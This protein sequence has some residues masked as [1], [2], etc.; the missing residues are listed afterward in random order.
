MPWGHIETLLDKLD[1]PAER[2]W[3]AAQAV[4]HG[5]TRNLLLNQIKGQL[6]LRV[7]AAPSNFEVT[8][9][10]NESELVQQ[11]VKDPYN[12]EFLGLSDAQSERELEASLVARI[13][14]FLLEMGHGFAF[15][16]RQVHIE[17]DGD[18]FFIDLLAPLRRCRAQDRQVRAGR[19]R[20]TQHVREHGRW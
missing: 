3:Y 14:D 17:I 20:T 16:G 11:M 9:T 4:R 10:D 12:F 2:D 8:V 13:R 19:R 15:V 1:D 7:G 6:H 18:D 5:W